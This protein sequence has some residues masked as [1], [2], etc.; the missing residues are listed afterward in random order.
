MKYIY[1]V[2]TAVAVFGAF[3]ACDPSAGGVRN[4]DYN[5][6]FD[7]TPPVLG[8][9]SVVAGD[10]VSFCFDEPVELN[11]ESLL[12]SGDVTLKSADPPPSEGCDEG[13][14]L[15]FASAL[16][17]GRPYTL[18]LTVRDM[19]GNSLD[20]VTEV[21]G[22]NGNVP[23]IV[24]NE[25]TTKGSGNHPDVVELYA[26]SGG[27]LA[28]VTLHEGTVSSWDHRKILPA[29]TVGAGDYILVHFKPEGITTEIDETT[30]TDESAG[31][32]AHPGAW[33]Y[34]V[35]GGSG[36]SGNNGMLSLYDAP[37]GAL[38]D[39]VIYSNRTSESDER[40]RGWGRAE[41]MERVDE[42]V[43]AGGWVPAGELL[44][45]EETVSSAR[46]TATRSMGRASTHADT[47]TAADWHTVPTSG[48]S[49]GGVNSDDVYEPR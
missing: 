17:A 35:A 41:V 28:G 24:I 46:T 23:S 49:F 11:R 6:M 12:I 3:A 10:Q 47:N 38:V 40:Y 30:R 45:P 31:K 36:L 48:Y 7:L 37:H 8:A 18:A 22:Y 39:A 9:V 2:L 25:F 15:T 44:T 13:V 42:L 43:R 29:A 34:W 33:D 21:Y 19:H 27:N 5:E 4:T 16:A 20:I 32:D 1:Y 14:L 26:V